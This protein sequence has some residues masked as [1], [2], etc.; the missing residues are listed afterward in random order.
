MADQG[1]SHDEYE[2]NSMGHYGSR[3]LGQLSVRYK[4]TSGRSR[5]KA[6]CNF[7]MKESVESSEKTEKSIGQK[8]R[9][10]NI[11]CKAHS[12]KFKSGPSS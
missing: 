7:N 2:N 9:S 8:P 6:T 4:D 11:M 1:F 3:S 12:L 5:W 10:L